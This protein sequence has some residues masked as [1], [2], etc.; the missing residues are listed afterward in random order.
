[1]AT[2]KTETQLDLAEVEVSFSTVDQ[3]IVA[4]FEKLGIK[5]GFSDVY[6]L[7]KSKDPKV[8]YEFVV[9]EFPKLMRKR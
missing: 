6:A 8:V 7:C 2:K 1:M 5:G 3:A 9:N 4:G